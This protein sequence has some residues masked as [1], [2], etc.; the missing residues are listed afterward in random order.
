MNDLLVGPST[1]Q[2]DPYDPR[3]A[4]L[5]K[6]SARLPRLNIDQIAKPQQVLLMGDFGWYRESRKSFATPSPPPLPTIEWHRRPTWH[7]I[8]YLDAHVEWVP[9]VKGEYVTAK[10]SIIPYLDLQAEI[11]AAAP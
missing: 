1:L 2:V 7:N 6:V 11:K 4:V 8:A 3:K 10:Y 9:I 5:N